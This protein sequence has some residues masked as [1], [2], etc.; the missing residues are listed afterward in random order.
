MT[1]H[2]ILFSG[3]VAATDRREGYPVRNLLQM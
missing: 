3:H 2:Q 1:R